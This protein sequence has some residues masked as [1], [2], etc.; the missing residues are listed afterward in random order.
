MNRKRLVMV[1]YVLMVVF[2]LAACGSGANTTNSTS[3]A[4][5]TVAATPEPIAT[6]EPP[7]EITLFFSSQ[8]TTYQEFDFSANWFMDKI[9]EMANVKF[10][11]VITPPA[12]DLI[13]KYNMLVASG[14]LPDL[15]VCPLATSEIDKYGKDGAFLPTDSYIEKSATISKIYNAAQ[16]EYIKADDGMT[17]AVW[18]YPSNAD[19]DSDKGFAYRADLLEKLSIQVP[20]T[21]NGWVDAMRIVKE[22]VPNSIPY[23]C[24]GM[25]Q[26]YQFIFSPYNIG[27]G[28]GMA[29]VFDNKTNTYTHAFATENMMKAVAFG[30]MLY[31][32]G[33]LDKEFMTH[34]KNDYT[35]KI[36]SRNMLIIPKNRGGINNFI[37]RF[38]TNG[39]ADAKV[40]PACYMAADGIEMT[41]GVY[42][43]FGNLV[44]FPMTISSATKSPDACV[45]VIEALLSD[46][47]KDLTV[48]GREGTE[49]KVV[50]GVKTAI[51]PATTDS[52]WR[53]AYGIM[54]GINTSERMNYNANA[55]I[56][57]TAITDE[58]KK[59]YKNE[60]AE[61]MT[62]L[63]QTI[64]VDA[65]RSD[66]YV[67]AISTDLATKRT[68]SLTLQTSLIAKAIMGEISLDEFRAEAAKVVANDA[69]I[70]AAMNKLV[71]DA[72]AKYGLK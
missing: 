10:T 26:Y 71:A 39:V 27:F 34:T 4:A 43:H 18:G 3:T 29:M 46:E 14:T 70:V 23:S 63:E 40:M 50:D 72:V 47:V 52:G 51:E 68:E 49:F 35:N 54:F 69:D 65:P 53:L 5:S 15:M 55:I 62:K 1:T 58:A 2:V 30:K 11:D 61:R 41:D 31:D 12:A 13:T 56:D 66:S 25:S 24:V 16:R 64:F 8:G 36:Y 44:G 42:K 37:S 38:P 20:T 48:Y 22:K 21:I 7:A 6:P 67:E 17:Y 9:C 45:R 60:L 33:L 28:S 59:A 57:A 32:E 19:F